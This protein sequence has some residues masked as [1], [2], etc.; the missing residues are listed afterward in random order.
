VKI[1]CCIPIPIELPALSA[2]EATWMLFVI[3]QVPTAVFCPPA[4]AIPRCAS[5]LGPITDDIAHMPSSSTYIKTGEQI[6]QGKYVNLPSHV[7][8]TCRDLN[9]DEY[10]LLIDL[11]SLNRGYQQ[12][13]P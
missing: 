10:I 12:G 11:S 7:L 6:T 3:Q 1:L 9:R 2:L 8:A 4:V 5:C 13:M